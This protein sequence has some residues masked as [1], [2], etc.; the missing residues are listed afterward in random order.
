M[1]LKEV[2]T[3]FE[4]ERGE[5]MRLEEEGTY[6]VGNIQGFE[7]DRGA[8]TGGSLLDPVDPSFQALCGR[9]K[10]TVRR[11]EYN[12]DSL[13]W[14]HNRAATKSTQ[15]ADETV[16]RLHTLQ[17][18]NGTIA[19]PGFFTKVPRD[20]SWRTSEALSRTIAKTNSGL[21]P[22]ATAGPSRGVALFIIQDANDSNVRIN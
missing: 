18:R 15:T 13:S 17:A 8:E 19:N 1:N 20:P 16:R 21:K 2:R 4:P 5:D 14:M 7:R 10:F 9:P 6:V 3:G 11:H 22:N 12:E